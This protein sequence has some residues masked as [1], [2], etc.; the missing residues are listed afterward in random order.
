MVEG[1]EMKKKLSEIIRE[2]E[3]A[4]AITNYFLHNEFYAGANELN[5]EFK[6][7]I[8]DKILEKYKIKEFEATAYWE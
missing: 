2:L 4:G 7:E 1:G 8:A 5:I 6:N 3:D